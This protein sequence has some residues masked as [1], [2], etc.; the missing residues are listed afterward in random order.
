MA[1]LQHTAEPETLAGPIPA[2]ADDLGVQA[3]VPAPF[4][5]LPETPVKTPVKATPGEKSYRGYSMQ[6]AGCISRLAVPQPLL[7]L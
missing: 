5:R 2:P 1:E 4:P 6:L 7:P 3:T